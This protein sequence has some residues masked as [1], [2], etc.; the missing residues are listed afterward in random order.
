[1]IGSSLTTL[2]IGFVGSLIIIWVIV[3]PDRIVPAEFGIV[4]AYSAAFGT[5]RDHQLSKQSAHKP[6]VA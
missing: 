4:F 6:T 3:L 2:A 5:N 1:L